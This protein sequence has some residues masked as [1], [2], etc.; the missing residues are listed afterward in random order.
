[1]VPSPRSLWFV[2]ASALAALAATC[3]ADLDGAPAP[4]PRAGK[5]ATNSIG[6]KL[7]RIPA[8]KFLMG[9]P[10][11]EQ[12]HNST[13]APQREVEITRPFYMGVH[14]VTQSEFQK[15]MGSNPSAYS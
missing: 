6:M 1:M 15:V 12:G 4:I 5:D 3:P 9:S 10:M 13:E 14:E 8:G 7:A 11:S 2:L